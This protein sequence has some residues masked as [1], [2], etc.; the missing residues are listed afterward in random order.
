MQLSLLINETLIQ[1][2]SASFNSININ[3]Y[4]VH[5]SFLFKLLFGFFLLLFLPSR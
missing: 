3:L 1:F 4:T 2:V 5:F